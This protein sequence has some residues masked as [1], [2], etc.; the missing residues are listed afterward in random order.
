MVSNRQKVGGIID[1]VLVGVLS[2]AITTTTMVNKP[3]QSTLFQLFFF[4]FLF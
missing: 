2:W 1:I 3:L 4:F